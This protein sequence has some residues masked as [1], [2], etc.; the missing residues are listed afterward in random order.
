M[1]GKVLETCLQTRWTTLDVSELKP[2]SM[3]RE[4]TDYEKLWGK[5]TK[6]HQQHDLGAPSRKRPALWGR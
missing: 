2:F 5:V 6:E 1:Q 3:E 4:I